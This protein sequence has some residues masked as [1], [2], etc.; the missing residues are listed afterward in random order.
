M[1]VEGDTSDSLAAMDAL[2]ASS[3]SFSPTLS[4]LY[5]SVFAVHN[6]TTLSTPLVALKQGLTLVHLS[7]QLEPCLTHKSTLHTLNTP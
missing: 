7:A 5:R 6:T 4:S 2:I 3:V 1:S